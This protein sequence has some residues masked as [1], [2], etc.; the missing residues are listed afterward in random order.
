MYIFPYS[1]EY[2]LIIF[3]ISFFFPPTVTASLHGPNN[4]RKVK[5]FNNNNAKKKFL[6][7][8]VILPTITSRR[9]ATKVV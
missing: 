7:T 5:S 1:Q 2:I 6:H 8:K 3:S 4:L 9:R